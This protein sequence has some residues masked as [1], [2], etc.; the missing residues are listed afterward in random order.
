MTRPQLDSAAWDVVSVQL[1]RRLLA[2]RTATMVAA[3]IEESGTKRVL[4]TSAYAK[5]GK[6]LFLDLVSREFEHCKSTLEIRVIDGDDI[7][8]DADPTGTT[9]RGKVRLEPKHLSPDV[10]T[11]IKGPSVLDS[12]G[13]LHFRRDWFEE[14]DGALVV[15]MARRTGRKA[16]RETVAWLEAS[17][18]KPIGLIYN[19]FASPPLADR[20]GRIRKWRQQPLRS[21]LRAAF[22]GLRRSR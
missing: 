5:E 18:I 12:E 3:A 9:S 7:I 4:V 15:V 20:L 21:K 16:L 13:M 17:G 19:E 1:E 11:L 10:V 8:T 22:G 14:I 6:T 2:R